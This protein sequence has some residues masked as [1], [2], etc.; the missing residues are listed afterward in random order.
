[1]AA[2][3]VLLPSVNIVSVNVSDF[4]R[5]TYR[6]FLTALLRMARNQIRDPDDAS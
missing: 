5:A 6:E 1:M 2:L 4:D 3:G